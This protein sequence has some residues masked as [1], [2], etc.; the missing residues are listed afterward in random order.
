MRRGYASLLVLVGVTLATGG[1]MLAVAS[2]SLYY[3]VAG[4]IQIVAGVL[5]WR[6]D[7]RGAWLYG[8][9]LVGTLAWAIWEVGDDTWGLVARLAMPCVLGIPVLLLPVGIADNRGRWVFVGAIV[10]ALGIGAGLHAITPRP[11][12]PLLQ[13]GT[14]AQAVEKSAQPSDSRK[15]WV[16]YGNDLGGTRFSPLTQ[17]TP[18]NV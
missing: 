1:A 10:L 18:Q 7:R 17:I 3:L 9:L 16:H 4:V 6:A 11:D 12:D 8:A 5:I 13:L 14:L 15:D 2:G